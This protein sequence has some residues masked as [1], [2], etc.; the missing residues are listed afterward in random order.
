[1]HQKED[2]RNNIIHKTN[3]TAS[4]ETTIVNN[5]NIHE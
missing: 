5:F 2:H 4:E 1:M 3:I